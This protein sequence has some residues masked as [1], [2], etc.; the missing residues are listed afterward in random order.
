MYRKMCR[1]WLGLEMHTNLSF[2]VPERKSSL[3]RQRQNG[4]F[5]GL[6]DVGPGIDNMQRWKVGRYINLKEVVMV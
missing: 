1:I 4:F 2:E 3:G 5:I 6:F